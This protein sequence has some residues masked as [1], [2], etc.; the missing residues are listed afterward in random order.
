MEFL[1]NMYY[2]NLFYFGGPHKLWMCPLCNGSGIWTINV[3]TACE[4]QSYGT[5]KSITC[6][7]CK[8]LKTVKIEP[9]HASSC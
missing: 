1:S 3:S 9:C 6:P 5:T 8:G 2:G 7:L 4:T